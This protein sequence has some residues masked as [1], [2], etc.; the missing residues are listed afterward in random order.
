VNGESEREVIGVGIERRASLVRDRVQF[1][2][3]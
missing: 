3:L 2:C 1:G